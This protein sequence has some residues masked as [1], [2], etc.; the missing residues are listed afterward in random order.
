MT[1]R[2]SL[3]PSV[4]CLPLAPCGH[5]LAMALLS[6]RAHKVLG[7]QGPVGAF[8]TVLACIIL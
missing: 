6:S 7:A 4:I 2:H 8:P 1:D 3:P 5:S